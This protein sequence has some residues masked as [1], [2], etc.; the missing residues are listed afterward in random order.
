[1]NVLVL[2]ARA[3]IAADLARALALAGHAVWLA[4]SF[5]CALAARS[6]SARGFVRLPAPRRDFPGF[7]AALA[8]ACRRWSFDAIVPVSEEVFWLA[9]A[10]PALPARVDVRTS[11]V[12]VLAGLHHKARF[13]RLAAGLG[14]GA[15]ENILLESS[16]A[17]A[18]LGDTTRYVLKPVYSRFASRTLIRPTART[19]LRV[20]PTAAQPW[21]AQTYVAGRELC[22][23][24]VAANG[25]LLLHV[26]Y[27]PVFRHGVG[28]SVYFA[29]VTSEPLRAMSARFVAA[30]GFTGQISF[31]AMVTDRGLV[32]LECNPR[33]TSGVHLAVQD[34]SSLASALLGHGDEGVSLPPLEPRML[35][36]PL[37][38]NRP[39]LVLTRAGRAALAASRDALRCAGVGPLA[40]L[41]AFSELAWHAARRRTSLAVAATADIEWNGEPFDA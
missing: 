11:P 25:R 35:V 28:A 22:A 27:E 16:A 26:A 37:L 41:C 1:M 5:R 14:Y 23:Y 13:A 30:T 10:A 40:K 7:R 29:P 20:R 4:D 17:L 34:P 6:P 21:L 3:P 15:P 24:N 18:S 9:A 39:G 8:A 33:G 32:A 36:L 12:A 19:A 38:L 2:G 31:D